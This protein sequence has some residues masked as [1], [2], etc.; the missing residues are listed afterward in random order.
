LD[1]FIAYD[2]AAAK[3]YSAIYDL[4]TNLNDE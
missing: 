4:R 2:N 3:D 1:W